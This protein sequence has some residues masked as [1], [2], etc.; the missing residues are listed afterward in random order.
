[1][2]ILVIYV[3]VGRVGQRFCDHSAGRRFKGKA[4]PD[5]IKS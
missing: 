4:C 1:M 3:L 5:L 2:V